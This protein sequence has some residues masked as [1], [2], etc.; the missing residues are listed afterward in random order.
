MN[1]FFNFNNKDKFLE[2]FLPKFEDNT[3]SAIEILFK[4]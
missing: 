1:F 4:A 2:H 3:Q